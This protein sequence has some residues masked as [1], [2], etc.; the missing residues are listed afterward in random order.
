[1]INFTVRE[2][3][4]HNMDRSSHGSYIDVWS[5]EAIAQPCY[6]KH[7]NSNQYVRRIDRE[8]KGSLTAGELQ[9]N[10]SECKKEERSSKGKV[11]KYWKQLL[12]VYNHTYTKRIQ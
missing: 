4:H 1:M 3:S 10:S 6:I 5:C 9:D 8:D 7:V 11:R 12:N 2:G